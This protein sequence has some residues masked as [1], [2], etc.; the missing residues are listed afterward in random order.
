MSEI[1]RKNEM[2][3]DEMR[4]HIK[5]NIVECVYEITQVGDTVSRPSKLKSMLREA[6]D[7]GDYRLF[8]YLLDH[9]IGKPQAKIE[10][11]VDQRP[12]CIVKRLDGT[13][14]EYKL[15]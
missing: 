12:L 8:L 1:I 9:V 6:I 15:S 5:Q 13:E 2:T 11:A 7:D 3:I 10:R 4:N 14:I